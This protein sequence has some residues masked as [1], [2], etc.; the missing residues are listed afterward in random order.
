MV[1]S[2]GFAMSVWC[3]VNASIIFM[4]MISPH[5]DNLSTAMKVIVSIIYALLFLGGMF[6]DSKKQDKIAKIEREIEKLKES[7]SK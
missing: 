6:C 4:F 7:A 2:G 1:L 3:A 5:F